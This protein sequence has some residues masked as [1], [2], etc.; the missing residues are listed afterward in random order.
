MRN[1]DFKSTI[2]ET[3]RKLRINQT[4]SE[5]ILWEYIRNRQLLNCKFLRQ[6]PIIFKWN[7]QKRFLIADFY[8]YEAKLIIELDGKIHDRQK[9]YDQVRDFALNAL[10]LEV[11][12]IKNI[13]VE[14]NIDS[15]IN[16]INSRLSRILSSS[17]F[18][19]GGI[20][21]GELAAN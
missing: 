21:G 16:L 19:R 3:V 9:N 20:K 2:K 6:F 5:S 10:G 18:K 14:K 1:Q 13:E 7:N 15:V 11:I 17:I 4:E 8:C 12:R